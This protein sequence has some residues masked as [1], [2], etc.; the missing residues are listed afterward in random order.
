MAGARHLIRAS[1]ELKVSYFMF[2][3][4]G[5]MK[6]IVDSISNYSMRRCLEFD[7]ENMTGEEILS[8]EISKTTAKGSKCSLLLP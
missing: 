4:P 2:A 1:S 8:E 3:E 6:G 5:V 7:D